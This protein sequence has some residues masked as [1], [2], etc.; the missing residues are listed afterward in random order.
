VT[1][2]LL[3]NPCIVFA[4]RRE[5]VPFRRDFRPHQRF[6]GA[7]CWARFCGPPGRT[8]LVLEIG[9]GRERVQACLEWLLKWPLFGNHP[10]RPR[11]VLSAGFSGA[12]QEEHAIGDIILATEV[13]DTAGQCWPATWPGELPPGQ[14]RVPL[15]RARLLTTSKLI[16][17]PA[18]K[19]LLGQRHAAA[20]VDMETA[21]VAEMCSQAGVPF[22][23]VRAI[24]DD[25]HT[26]LS[27][28]LVALLSGGRVS[29]RR[30]LWALVRS[31]GLLSEMRRLARQTRLAAERLASALCELLTLTTSS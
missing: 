28:R 20:A 5:A 6:A 16:G 29:P 30:L 19:R 15:H 22:G 10:Y 13:A 8:V 18:E 23:C 14:G 26:A 7:P 27:P 17:T 1:E 12:L 31:P 21:V 11:V 24:S 2:R 25:V 9:V 3:D 4:L